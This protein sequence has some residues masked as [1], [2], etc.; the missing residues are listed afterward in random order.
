MVP[1]ADFGSIK[2]DYNPFPV[3]GKEKAIQTL[4]EKDNTGDPKGC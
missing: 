4:S 3:D 2:W 1:E